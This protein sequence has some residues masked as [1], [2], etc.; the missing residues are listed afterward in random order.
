[1]SKGQFVAELPKEQTREWLLSLRVTI[2]SLVSLVLG[3][4]G[5][6]LTAF[7]QHQFISSFTMVQL[8]RAVR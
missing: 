3:R 5:K 2:P 1:M 6:L 8:P 7:R 4:R